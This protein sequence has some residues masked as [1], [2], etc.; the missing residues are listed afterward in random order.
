MGEKNNMTKVIVFGTFDLIHPGHV[1][2]LKE[3]KEY[4][5]FLIVVVA[6]DDT[7][8]AVKGKAPHYNEEER[9]ENISKLKIA[10]KVVLGCLDPEDRYKVIADEKPDIIA[11]GY[12]QKVFVDKLAD[13]IDD[14]V[15]I[16]RISP[17]QPDLYKS[18]KLGV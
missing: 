18:S 14:N 10:D 1:Y 2:L 5:D 12:D 7:V 11:L 6:R 8:C 3:A 17:F 13:A 16:V 15:K 9:V 4:G